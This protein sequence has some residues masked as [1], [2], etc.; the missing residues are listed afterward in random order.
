MQGEK[1]TAEKRLAKFK[2]HV[3]FFRFIMFVVRLFG[4]GLWLW[5]YLF[6]DSGED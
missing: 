2:K 5:N 4:Y 6:A 1:K 3:V